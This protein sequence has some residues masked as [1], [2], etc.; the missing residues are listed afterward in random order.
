VLQVVLVA[1][2]LQLLGLWIEAV[3]GVIAK[4]NAKTEAAAAAAEEEGGTADSAAEAAMDAAEDAA[5]EAASFESED[6][7]SEGSSSASVDDHLVQLFQ[8]T[9]SI[10]EGF[11]ITLLA[12]MTQAAVWLQQQLA[13]LEADWQQQQQQQQ[14]QQS[15]AAAAAA[16]ASCVQSRLIPGPV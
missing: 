10:T 11:D 12:C 2:S 7:A 13:L 14:Q 9:V 8:I 4:R 16:A 5:S 1:H 6:A 3:L 15:P